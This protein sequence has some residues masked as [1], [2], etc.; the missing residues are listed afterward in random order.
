MIYPDGNLP[1]ERISHD[2]EID[3]TNDGVPAIIKYSNLK[4]TITIYLAMA[5]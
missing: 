1:N 2:E 5:N 4:L 3:E